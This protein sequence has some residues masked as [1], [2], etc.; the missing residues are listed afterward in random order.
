MYYK[1]KGLIDVDDQNIKIN[2]D[3]VN[4]IEID[5][6]KENSGFPYETIGKSAVLTIYDKDDENKHLYILVDDTSR[7]YYLRH[8]VSFNIKECKFILA[9]NQVL[10]KWWQSI[11]LEDDPDTSYSDITTIITNIAPRYNPDEVN[12]LVDALAHKDEHVHYFKRHGANNVVPNIHQ[13]H[14][15]PRINMAD[16]VI[17][18]TVSGG[19]NSNTDYRIWYHNWQG[20]WED[21]IVMAA[22]RNG[23]TT[24]M[25]FGN[26]S[27]WDAEDVEFQHG[28]DRIFVRHRENGGI[29]DREVLMNT[30]MLWKYLGGMGTGGT[31]GIPGQAVDVMIVPR[32]ISRLDINSLR[33][34]GDTRHSLSTNAKTVFIGRFFDFDLPCFYVPA[35]L[36]YGLHGT[37]YSLT[38]RSNRQLT[39]GTGNLS[40]DPGNGVMY[41]N[42]EIDTSR[43]YPWHH[44]EVWW[45]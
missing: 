36:D 35:G 20:G 7:E 28:R 29:R 41:W 9:S 24:E 22:Y 5:T 1:N 31:V 2:N 13:Y 10:D 44:Y 8:E 14:Q 38:S 30:D 25:R 34:V 23:W 12:R 27:D 40:H 42:S 3:D 16:S 11:A 15:F 4:L 39:F 37:S 18:M 6:I 26:Y 32:F 19:R 33:P 17:R 43:S 45:R 21:A